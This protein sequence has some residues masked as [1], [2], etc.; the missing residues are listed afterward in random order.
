M[1]TVEPGFYEAE[2][3][4]R[5]DALFAYISSN[6][7]GDIASSHEEYIWNVN[8][9]IRWCL[10]RAIVDGD[11]HQMSKSL[12][13][14]RTAI[15]RGWRERYF[16]EIEKAGWDAVSSEL[17]EDNTIHQLVVMT[18][19][20]PGQALGEDYEAVWGRM[21]GAIDAALA[22]RGKGGRP[23][24]DGG[25]L[26]D[27]LSAIVGLVEGLTGQEIKP[28][29]IETPTAAHRHVVRIG[30]LYAEFGRFGAVETLKYSTA[31]WER[32]L[33]QI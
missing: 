30:G 21:V 7:G 17:F 31:A 11:R 22:R 15:L 8:S 6:F 9:T 25:P 2:A 18:Q 1:E 24:R 19:A 32:I 10:G 26:D 4:P 16:R 3:D 23:A 20:G 13:R 33:K 12:K 14:I 28:P 27:A 5:F 29:P